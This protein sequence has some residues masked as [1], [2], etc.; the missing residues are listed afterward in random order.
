MRNFCSPGSNAG[1]CNC[2][3]EA[4]RE[5]CR[6]SRKRNASR[7]PIIVDEA[8]HLNKNIIAPSES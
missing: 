1:R 3:M 2:P 5:N 7:K 8:R 6:D 4:A